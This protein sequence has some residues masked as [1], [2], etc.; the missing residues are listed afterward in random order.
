MKIA[1][2]GAGFCGVAVSLELLNQRKGEVTLYDPNG[3]GGGASGIAAGLLHPFAGLHSKLNWNGFEGMAA[4]HALIDVAENHLGKEVA[5]RKGILRP[6]LIESQYEDFQLCAKQYPNEVEWLEAKD[7]AKRFPGVPERPGIF[8]RNG[9]TVDCK[10]YLEGLWKGCAL[11]GGKFIQ[12]KVED[13]KEFD[14]VI[15][16]LGAA[17]KKFS[18]LENLPLAFVKGQILEIEFP[19]KLPKLPCPLNSQVYLTSMH[20]IWIGGSTFERGYTDD[21]PDPEIAKKILW[22]KLVELYPPLEKGKIKQVRAGIRVVA[23]NHLPSLVKVNEKL[24]SLTGMGSKG[25]L[26]HA[27]MAQKLVSTII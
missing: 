5:D 17:T 13:L 21:N 14:L 27:L 25:L 15:A 6:A 20:G 8:I 9:L 2:L 1:V 22:D 11:K 7:V 18:G 4:T 12:E 26:W 16:C 24:Y 3:I 19:E 23:P 10:S